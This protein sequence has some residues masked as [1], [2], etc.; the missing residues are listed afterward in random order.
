MEQGVIGLNA[1][2]TKQIEF[3]LADDAKQPVDVTVKEIKEKVLPELDDELARSASEFDTLAELRADIE[4]RLRDQ[5]AEEVEAQFRSDVVDA[6]VARV[7]GGRLRA[8]SSRRARGSCCA[9]S[10]GRSRRAASRSTR[11]SR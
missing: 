1:G 8:R 3:E 4:S 10:R 9:G 2:E 11:I 5:I 7:E 6:L